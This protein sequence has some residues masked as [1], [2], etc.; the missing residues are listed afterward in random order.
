MGR[1][2]ICDRITTFVTSYN[3]VLTDTVTQIW[4]SPNL[5]NF[6]FNRTGIREFGV[7]ISATIFS[8]SL[9]FLQMMN[10]E[11]LRQLVSFSKRLPGAL[12]HKPSFLSEKLG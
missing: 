2:F 1:F 12:H 8:N 3:T 4:N 10:K 9:L 5:N 6:R 11:W 7:N